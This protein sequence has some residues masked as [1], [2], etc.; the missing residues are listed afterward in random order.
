[1]SS[2]LIGILG[3]S[4]LGFHQRV[5]GY[6]HYGIPVIN[7]VVSRRNLRGLYYHDEVF[8]YCPQSNSNGMNPVDACLELLYANSAAG[9]YS[10]Y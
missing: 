2:M 9:K 3:L 8:G 7:K 1:M 4:I 5:F 10:S 6:F